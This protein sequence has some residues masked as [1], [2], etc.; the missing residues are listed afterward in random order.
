MTTGIG[1]WTHNPLIMW[2]E[3]SAGMDDLRRAALATAL[4]TWLV[5]F[6]TPWYRPRSLRIFRDCTSLSASEDLWQTIEQ[7]CFLFSPDPARVARSST[8]SLG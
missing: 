7:A 6:A 3:Q 1:I 5:R 8:V 2:D 4:Q